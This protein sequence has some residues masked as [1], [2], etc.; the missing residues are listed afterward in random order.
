LQSRKQKTQAALQAS[1]SQPKMHK[2]LW[3]RL[4][5]K[6]LKLSTVP[7]DMKFITNF[8]VTFFQNY[9][10]MNYLQPKLC[11]VTKPLS[12]SLGMLANMKLKCREVIIGLQSWIVKG[13]VSRSMLFCVLHKPKCSG[14]LLLTNTMC[15][16][17]HS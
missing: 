2:I 7:H 5:L 12:I 14:L 1:I 11:L 17:R 16:E 15:C 13:R 9:K 6:E 8:A 3:A 4:K 10:R